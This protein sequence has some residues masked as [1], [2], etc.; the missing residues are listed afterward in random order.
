M[1]IV[2]SL[3]VLRKKIK[4]YHQQDK[5]IAFIPTMGNLHNGHIKL[6]NVGSLKADIVIV[7]IFVNPIQFDNK[8][9]LKKYPRTIDEDFKQL[10]KHKVNI[11]FV[12]DQ[13][14]IYNN[15][16]NLQTTV[17]VPYYSSILEGKTRPGHFRGVAT[18][19]CKFFNLI[20]PNIVCFGEKDFQQLLLIRQLILDMNY[21]IKIISVPT[22][23]DNDGLALSSRNN[24]LTFEE[25]QRAANIYKILKKVKKQ[26]LI[27]NHKLT[28]LLKT[29]K[30]EFLKSGIQ[31]D[32]LDIRDAYTL[33]PI[34]CISKKAV[35]LFSGLVGKTRLIDNMQINLFEKKDHTL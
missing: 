12:P 13:S 14:A 27:S 4:E 20:K 24:Y 19:I 21:D 35:L 5:T 26:L 1:L 22:V 15:E 17:D 30:E 31:P 2:K 33:K 34:T 6:I 16:I 25:R 10:K 28:D 11:V 29:A 3:L 7:S 9:D 23:R 8:K 18:I 32:I